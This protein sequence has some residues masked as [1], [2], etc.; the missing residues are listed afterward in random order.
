MG[1]RGGLVVD[2]LN[3]FGFQSFAADFTLLVFAAL[4][5]GGG[6]LVNDPVAGLVSGGIGVVTLV[7][8]AAV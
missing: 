7:S 5:V 6:F 1:V 8:V 3:F 2:F 4:A